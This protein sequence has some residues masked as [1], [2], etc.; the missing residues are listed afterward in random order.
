[1][2]WHETGYQRQFQGVTRNERM[3]KAR[4]KYSPFETAVPM[5]LPISSTLATSF[6]IGGNAA[7]RELLSLAKPES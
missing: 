7:H 6:E 4:R 5:C 3:A 2:L 1:M